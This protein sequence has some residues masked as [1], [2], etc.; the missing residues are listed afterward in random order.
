MALEGVEDGD[1]SD[2]DHDDDLEIILLSTMN[3][4]TPRRPRL[5]LEDIPE[6][7]CEDMFRYFH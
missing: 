3:P 5:N 1:D 6:D 4:T 7:E 2:V